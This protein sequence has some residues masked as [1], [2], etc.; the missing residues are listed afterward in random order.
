MVEHKEEHKEHHKEEN[1]KIKLP[2]LNPW[3][4]VSLVLA[5]AL[6]LSLVKGWSVNGN[7][8]SS[9]SL[10]AAVQ[11][12]ITWLSNYFEAQGVDMNVTLVN[13]SQ[14]EN[15]VYQFTVSLGNVEQTYYV[16]KDGE[17]FF[18]QGIQTEKLSQTSQQQNT[19][20]DKPN[21]ELYIF[22]YCP[23]G[24]A[25]LDSFSETAS[26]LKDYANFKVKFFSNMHGEHEL[27]ENMI[28]ECIQATSPEKYWDYAKQYL[29][30]VYQKCGSSRSIECDKNESIKLMTAVGINSDNVMDCVKNQGETYYQQDI[31]DAS[32]L[33]LSYSPSFVINGE[34][35]QDVD[36]S[37][38]GIKSIVCSAFNTPPSKCSQT[39]SST[40]SAA[41]GGC[42]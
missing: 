5:I 35:I 30:T 27:Q 25:A 18:P 9:I 14:T 12:A 4:L 34:Y 7:A 26:F 15:G 42:G 2:R 38:E 32:S 19:K 21:V 39:I 10:Q 28:Q 13:A 37:P 22:S 6:A 17:L 41:S 29:E 8:G 36:R 11:K 31:N 3:I 33:Q 1:I 23:A 16:S 20:T 24:S 40:G